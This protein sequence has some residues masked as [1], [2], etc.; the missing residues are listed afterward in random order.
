VFLNSH[1][2]TEVERVCDRIAIVRNGRVA[3]Q[4]T[5][6]EVVGEQHVLRVRARANGTPIEPNL[7][8]FGNVTREGE[9]FLVEGVASERVPKLVAD[10]VAANAEV[11]AI[12][13]VGMTLEERFLQLTQ[14]TGE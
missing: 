4:G 8:A 13:P 1:L 10:L 2:L 3:A 9:T 7:A 6:A 14:G 5:I 11:F 12:E